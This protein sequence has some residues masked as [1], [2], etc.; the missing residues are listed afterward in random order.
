MNLSEHS[1]KVDVWGIKTIINNPEESPL[2]APLPEEIPLVFETETDQK[3][4]QPEQPKYE[5]NEP[6]PENAT[7]RNRW[8]RSVSGGA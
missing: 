5:G 8:R 3:G 7:A 2:S 1:T 4:R 6:L